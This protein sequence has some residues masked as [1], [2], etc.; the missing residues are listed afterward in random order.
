MTPMAI[1]VGLA[2]ELA[3]DGGAAVGMSWPAVTSYRELS[4]ISPVPGSLA[5]VG[6]DSVKVDL[7]AGYT[8]VLKMFQL[9]PAPKS[10]SKA[11]GELVGA[12]PG[13]TAPNA[14]ASMSTAFGC[15]LAAA[16]TPCSFATAA[17]V[18]PTSTVTKGGG[19]ELRWRNCCRRVEYIVSVDYAA[20]GRFDRLSFKTNLNR[21]LG[22]YGGGG[23]N[24]SYAVTPGERLGCMAGRSGSAIRPTHVL[25]D[26]IE[27]TRDAGRLA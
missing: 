20:G 17:R 18:G 24:G 26:R 10:A 9:P 7:V 14:P 22:P 3:A 13:T 4:R 27:L 11:A 15:A 1:S 25:V 19:A 8:K 21:V 5:L 12:P 6:G 2:L 23:F 16:S